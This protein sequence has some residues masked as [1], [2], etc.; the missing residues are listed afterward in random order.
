MGGGA[1][2]LLKAGRNRPESA[3]QAESGL[4]GLWKI[5]GIGGMG[6][7]FLPG[8]ELAGQFYA[9]VVWP[10]LDR[11]WPGLRYRIEGAGVGRHPSGIDQRAERPDSRCARDGT[12]TKAQ[13]SAA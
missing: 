5:L 3:K 13:S 8:L 1:F 6:M 9:D 11:R 10:R 7:P 4:A 12:G 2:I